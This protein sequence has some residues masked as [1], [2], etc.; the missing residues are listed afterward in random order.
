M[1]LKE[2]VSNLESWAPTS[3]AEKWDNVGLLVEP[4][5]QHNVRSILL[6][7]DLTEKVLQEAIE[8]RA[9][10][11]IS[12]HPPIFVPLKRLTSK[13]FKER[14]IVKAIEERIAIYSPHTAFDA[15]F[16]G[17]NDWLAKGLGR[18][19]VDPITYSMEAC[20]KGCDYNVTA[21]AP[22]TEAAEKI[23]SQIN[24]LGG[25]G[26]NSIGK[27]ERFGDP[28]LPKIV[29]HCSGDTLS[30]VMQIL[31]S[32]TIYYLEIYQLAKK[33]I[34]GTGSGRLCTLDT[35][36]TL[37]DIIHRIKKHLQLPHLR[38]AYAPSKAKDTLLSTVALCAGSGAS[39]LQGVAADV[40]LTG[41]MSH[42]EVLEAVSRGVHVILCEHSNTERGFLV[43][44]RQQLYNMLSG[45]VQVMVSETDAD[46]LL[47]V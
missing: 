22:S 42:H 34:P 3:L 2:V 40:Y 13:S 10:M 38:V 45:Q 23:N 14:I 4:S 24:S 36:V 39:V 5:G 29:T 44:F 28:A 47:V 11:I 15:V 41:E 37:P 18:G 16:G 31:Q 19:S 43:P 7:N 27:T 6:T 35:P 17:V 8:K 46:P 9:N 20:V 12:Y 30:A 26:S 21:I 25:I 32:Y 1:D 33:P